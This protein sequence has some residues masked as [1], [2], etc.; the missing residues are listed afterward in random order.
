M[1]RVETNLK[2]IKIHLVGFCF[3]ICE[4]EKVNLG[5]NLKKPPVKTKLKKKKIVITMKLSLRNQIN[6]WKG[7]YDK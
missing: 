6:E 7:H 4:Y 3:V 2:F 5:S 1:A